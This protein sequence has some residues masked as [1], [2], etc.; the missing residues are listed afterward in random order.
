MAL[1]IGGCGGSDEGSENAPRGSWAVTESL[2][3]D[4]PGW[5]ARLAHEARLAA[6]AKGG[7]AKEGEECWLGQ[8]LPGKW[9]RG[10]EV[11][12][13]FE[14]AHGIVKSGY[15]DLNRPIEPKPKKPKP[16]GGGGFTGVHAE[17]YEIAKVACGQPPKAQAARDLGLPESADEFAI[18]EEYA[19]A[20][21]PAFQ[22]AN[23]E[24]CLDG[25]LGK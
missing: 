10:C 2:L 16:A 14:R 25:L 3:A 22:Q 20:Y 23:F 6:E 21:Q 11:Y 24:G 18:A 4:S 9:P 15:Q 12:A 5:N 7:T 13:E 1:V 19:S 17:N 8:T